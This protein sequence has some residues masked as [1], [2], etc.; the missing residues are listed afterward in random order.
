MNKFMLAILVLAL[1]GC[2]TLTTGEQYQDELYSFEVTNNKV[3]PPTKVQAIELVV[4]NSEVAGEVASL[5][6]QVPGSL[7]A[8]SLLPEHI[9]NL[10]LDLQMKLQQKTGSGP[11][12]PSLDS[13]MAGF[14]SHLSFYNGKRFIT[15]GSASAMFAFDEASVENLITIL[16]RLEAKNTPK[17]DIASGTLK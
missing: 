7:E 16:E 2:K 11:Y 13:F 10:K 9:S 4:N 3:S 14:I 17:S 5:R 1:V 12:V 15:V 6:L 8:F